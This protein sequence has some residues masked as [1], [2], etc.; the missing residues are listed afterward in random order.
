MPSPVYRTDK[1]EGYAALQKCLLR[2]ESRK[3]PS[4]FRTRTKRALDR[5]IDQVD[6]ESAMDPNHLERTAQHGAVTIKRRWVPTTNA[7]ILV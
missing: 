6:Y 7:G 2:L 3:T 1:L 4:T 5:F